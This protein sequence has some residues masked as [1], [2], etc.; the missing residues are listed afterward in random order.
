MQPYA[1]ERQ[2]EIYL[3]G[4]AGKTPSI[5]FTAESLEKAAKKVLSKKAFA[6]IAGGAGEEKTVKQNRSAFDHWQ[7]VPHML[8]NVSERDTSITLLNKKLPAPFLL[9]PVGVLS[10]AHSD[11]DV[12]VAKAAATENIPYIFSNQASVPM[13]VC[14]KA[15]VDKTKWFQLYSSKSRELVVSFLQRAEACGCEA[16]VVT[17]DTTM[18]GWRPRDLQL[19]YLPFLEGKGI[20]Q[21]TSDPVFTELLKTYQPQQAK[22]T[23]NIQTLRGLISIVNHYPGKGLIKKLKSGLPIKAVQLFTEMYTNPYTTWDDLQFLRE[24]TRLPIFLKGILHAQDAQRALDYGVD[25]II[26]SNHGGRQVDGAIATLDALP[27]IAKVVNKQI[28]VLLDSGVRS[29]A[30]VF[31]AIAL[32]ANAVCFGRPYVYALAIDGENGVKQ[33]IKNIKAEF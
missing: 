10:L 13:E 1:L 4:F 7:I 33:W 26:V 9:A 17:L 2:K 5:P 29:G 19:A 25:G 16:L 23:I 24:H 27:Q 6:Y 14:A 18:L 22:R 20:A 11:A 31:K 8:K 15:M 3:N 32:G 12:A 30:D 28:P 21:Y